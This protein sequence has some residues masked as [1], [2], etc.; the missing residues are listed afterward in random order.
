MRAPAIRSP[1]GIAHRR[2]RRGFLVLGGALAIALPPAC[3]GEDPERAAPESDPAAA[4]AAVHSALRD[5]LPLPD[6]T[7]P[8]PATVP[9]PRFGLA[10]VRDDARV[11]LRAAPGGR[12]ITTLG[13]RT[14]FDSPRTVWIRE[15]RGDWFGVPTPALGNGRL[16]WIRD[17]RTKLEVYQTQFWIRADRSARVLELRYGDRLLDTFPVTVGRPGSETP[18]GAYS[19]TDALAGSGL[20]PWYG[21]CALALSGRQPNLPPGWFGGDRMAI[22]GTPGEVG[23]ADSAGCLRTSDETMVSLFARVPLGTPVFVRA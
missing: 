2:L 11:R 21:C 7:T 8:A 15:I 20:G 3:G 10:R 9:G 23:G 18:L 1:G 22:H 4:A 5:A 14:E 13:D 19:I 17:D 16:G 6:L 12:A